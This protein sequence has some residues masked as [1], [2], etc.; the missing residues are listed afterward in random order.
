MYESHQQCRVERRVLVKLLVLDGCRV[1]SL[2]GSVL[3][4][5]FSCCTVVEGT[6]DVSLRF[7]KSFPKILTPHASAST[8]DLSAL[9]LLLAYQMQSSLVHQ[10]VFAGPMLAVRAVRGVWRSVHQIYS[11]VRTIGR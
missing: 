10:L 11:L 3:V 7:N 5:V 2:G 8:A 9:L 4:G 1:S 6:N